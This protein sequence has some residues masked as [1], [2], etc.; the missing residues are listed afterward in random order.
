MCC[1][2]KLSRLIRSVVVIVLS[3][4]SYQQ[5]F[6]ESADLGGE[7]STQTQDQSL[8]TRTADRQINEGAAQPR[9]TR[10]EARKSRR[11][12]RQAKRLMRRGARL[13]LRRAWR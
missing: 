12:A 8:D 5:A 1:S 11:E 10:K 9:Q 7:G 2:S 3:V 13:S 4:T 6:A